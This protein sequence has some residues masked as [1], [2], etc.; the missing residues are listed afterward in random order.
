MTIECSAVAGRSVYD[1]AAGRRR[2]PGAPR[3]EEVPG[4]DLALP[5]HVDR[6][7]RLAVELLCDQVVGRTCDLH[8]PGRSVG[9]HA[10]RRV[11]GVAPEVVEEA[12][13]A[14]NAGHDGARVDADAKLEAEVPEL[15]AYAVEHVER[16]TRKRVRVIGPRGRYPG[17]DHVAIADRLD[18][19]EPVPLGELVEVGEQAVEVADHLRRCVAL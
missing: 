12:L 11:D 18:L 19:L 7:A 16:H 1:R 10:A 13:P 5:F 9:L 4:L 17:G 8:A 3:A 15:G 6:P 2:R 14:D